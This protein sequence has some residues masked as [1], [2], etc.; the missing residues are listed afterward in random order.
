ML[1]RKIKIDGLDIPFTRG[2]PS[3]YIGVHSGAELSAWNLEVTLYADDD[4]T[5]MEQLL[6]KSTVTVE[7]GFAGR[8]YEATPTRKLTSYQ[9]GRPGKFYQFEVKEV[10]PVR[11]FEALEIEGQS[12]S[13]IRNT[14]TFD[15]DVV[16]IHVLLG[17][18]SDEFHCFHRL[19]KPG[20]IQI[21]RM[22]IDETPIDQR[23]GGALYWS[24]D[25]ERS[26]LTYKQ[27]VNIYPADYPPSRWAIAA[28]H[29]QRALATMVLDLSARYEALLA[30]LV[31][32]GTLT[33][34]NAEML[35][36]APWD[37]LL[38]SDRQTMV[39]SRLREIDDA[40][41]DFDWTFFSK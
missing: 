8:Q 31:D 28:E 18:S 19:V 40:E 16:G 25:K 27:I 10:D 20:P 21:R 14:E 38:D 26:P 3:G 9:Q 32:S 23:F 11:V 34:E 39:R 12:F 30:L 29:E 15:D 2:D 36:Q 1:D 24:L 13:V 6:N 22:G 33:Q 4:I 35:K 5:H 17:L 41:L 37:E 7:D